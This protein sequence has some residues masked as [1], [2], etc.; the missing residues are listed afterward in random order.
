MEP[1]YPAPLMVR[2]VLGQ[3]QPIISRLK[4]LLDYIIIIIIIIF[5]IHFPYFTAFQP[6]PKTVPSSLTKHFFSLM[7][8]KFDYIARIVY[9]C[10][11]H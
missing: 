7:W 5:K 4:L 6:V 2:T 3:P 9:Y 11:L 1:G 10:F 8:Q